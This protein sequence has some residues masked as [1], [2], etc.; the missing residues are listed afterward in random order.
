MPVRPLSASRTR[1]PASSRNA[2]REERTI[3]SSSIIRTVNRDWASALCTIVHQHLGDLAHKH[4][5]GEGLGDEIDAILQKSV[6]HRHIAGIAGH[7]QH[8]QSRDDLSQ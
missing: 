5:G 1:Y 2:A 7:E 3:R 4:L 6:V 8:L